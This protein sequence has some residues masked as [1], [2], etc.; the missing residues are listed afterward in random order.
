M[1][2]KYFNVQNTIN[3]KMNDIKELKILF[4]YLHTKNKINLLKNMIFVFIYLRQA[5]Y[6]WKKEFE[7][8]KRCEMKILLMYT[9]I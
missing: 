4:I 6:Y 5:I 1:K 9:L 7:I 8:K 3:G 2:W